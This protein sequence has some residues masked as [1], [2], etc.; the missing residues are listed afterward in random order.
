ME[1]IIEQAS[2]L[3]KEPHPY[4]HVK[5]N[6]YLDITL[7]PHAVAAITVEYVPEHGGMSE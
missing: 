5:D 3:W 6:L 7:P 2:R 4:E 1:H